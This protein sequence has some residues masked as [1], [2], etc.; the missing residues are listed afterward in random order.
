M[1]KTVVKTCLKIGALIM[2]GGATLINDKLANDN[3]KETVVKT[4]DEALKDQVKGS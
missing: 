1:N 3:M 2:A 4:V